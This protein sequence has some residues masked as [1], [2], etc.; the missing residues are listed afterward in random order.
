MAAD[1]SSFGARSSKWFSF[2]SFLRISGKPCAGK[3][4]RINEITN[5]VL[6]EATKRWLRLWPYEINESYELLT[7]IRLTLKAAVANGAGHS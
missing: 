3:M 2:V 5:S 4:L 7:R 6:Q 1:Q